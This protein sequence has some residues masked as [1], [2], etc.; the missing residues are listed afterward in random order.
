MLVGGQPGRGPQEAL[1]QLRCQGR[2]EG[3]EALG[4][5]GGGV[6][7]HL[8]DSKGEKGGPLGGFEGTGGVLWDKQE[9]QEG[10]GGVPLRAPWGGGL[11][12]IFGGGT[13]EGVWKRDQ[14]GPLGM[15]N[16]V[17]GGILGEVRGC[18]RGSEGSLGRGPHNVL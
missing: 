4:K 10:L 6:R 16:G 11:K 17:W 2:S 13:L 7:G 9:G 5:L 12:G 1:L 3:R 14:E 8:E 15:V 18:L